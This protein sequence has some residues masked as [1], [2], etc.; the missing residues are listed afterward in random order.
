[1]VFVFFSAPKIGEGI[2]AD[3]EKE[4]YRR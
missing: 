4:R 3:K 2:E 1:M